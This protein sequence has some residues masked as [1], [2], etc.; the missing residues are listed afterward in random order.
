MNTRDYRMLF[1]RTPIYIQNSLDLYIQYSNITVTTL[2]LFG[3]Q[4]PST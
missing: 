4:N 1:L 3:T 2:Q